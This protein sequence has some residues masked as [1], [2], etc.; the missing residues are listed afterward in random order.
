MGTPVRLKTDESLTK[1]GLLAVPALLQY[2]RK[3][4]ETLFENHT[5]VW[6]SAYN[7]MES[8]TTH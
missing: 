7:M 8:A 1:G 2:P 5:V 3:N 6:M 4:P